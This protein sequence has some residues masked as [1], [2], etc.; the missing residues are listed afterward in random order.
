MRMNSTAPI[1]APD[2]AQQARDYQ[3]IEQALAYLVDHYRHQPSLAEL[4][5]AVNLSEAHFQRLFTRWAGVSPKKCLQALTLSDAKRSLARSTS[6]LD[7]SLGSGLSGS[8]RLHDLFVTV[9]AM[10]PGEFKRK[11]QGMV[12]AYGYHDTPFGEA[13]ILA[14][15][16]GLTGLAFV[17]ADGRTPALL[18]M[19]ARLPLALYQ[20]NHEKTGGYAQLLWHHLQSR[21]GS[22]AASLPLLLAGTPFQLQVWQ[23]LL[24]VPVGGRVSYRRLA[25]SLGKP[26]A[27]R[28]VG[29]AVG[30][31]PISWL[32]PCHRVLR[33][34]G[35]LGGYH[36]GES[37]KI[38]MLCWEN[39]RLLNECS[40]F[41]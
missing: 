18:D 30:R 39:A 10:T 25:E 11:G 2:A 19:Q 40:A 24:R 21:G 23:A 6:V 12:I 32:I 14:T 5:A 41:D 31:N 8:S 27:S 35:F 26:T 3:R 9:E 1:A 28:A 4:A 34:D 36:W 38:S 15:P 13:L 33:Q 37:R 17:Q 20:E 29:S 22:G 7:A 16:R